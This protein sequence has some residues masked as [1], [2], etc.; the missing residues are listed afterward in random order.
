[1]SDAP[2]FDRDAT[3]EALDMWGRFGPPRPGAGIPLSDLNQIVQAARWAVEVTEGDGELWRGLRPLA[4]QGVGA[5]PGGRVMRVE[6]VTEC[7]HGWVESHA[8][9]GEVDAMHAGVWPMCPGGSRR[10]LAPGEAERIIA[11]VLAA[12]RPCAE[13]D[14]AILDAAVAIVDALAGGE[15][16]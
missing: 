10:V 6:I 16:P 2:T 8:W 15:Q 12:L 3:K 1:M 7:E 5:E 13:A 11:R 14:V 4:I 9:P